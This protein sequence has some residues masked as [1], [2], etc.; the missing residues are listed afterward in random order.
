MRTIM[1]AIEASRRLAIFDR[2]FAPALP[3]MRFI[4]SA[5]RNRIPAIMITKQSQ[6]SFIGSYIRP[7]LKES[8]A[9]CRGSFSQRVCRSSGRRLPLW[10]ERRL[11]AQIQGDARVVAAMEKEGIHKLV[12]GLRGQE[13]PPRAPVGVGFEELRGDA[14]KNFGAVNPLS[15]VVRQG[16]QK[17]PLNV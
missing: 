8:N 17:N 10:D 5:K 6:K 9:S 13:E 4:D 2:I 14:S 11:A 1:T 15:C 3:K 7:I 12:T 16:C